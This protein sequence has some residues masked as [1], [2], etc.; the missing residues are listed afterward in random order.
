LINLIAT[1]ERYNGRA[2]FVQGFVRI[3]VENQS[4]CLTRDPASTRDCIW[5]NIDAGPYDT[6][7][8]IN[9]VTST[10]KRWKVLN[11]KMVTVQGVFDSEDTGHLG[12]SS[13]GLENLEIMVSAD[14]SAHR[15]HARH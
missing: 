5:L 9:R 10:L 13:G 12:A 3:G 2:I 6:D 15:Q 7:A 1:P 8:D 4:I 14:A 11:G